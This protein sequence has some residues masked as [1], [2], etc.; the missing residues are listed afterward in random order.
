MEFA[1]AWIKHPYKD[2][3][4]N[5][6]STSMGFGFGVH[7][8]ESA[9]YLE[10]FGLGLTGVREK[11]SLDISVIPL[12]LSHGSKNKNRHVNE[13]STSAHRERSSRHMNRHIVPT[14]RDQRAGKKRKRLE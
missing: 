12:S 1:Y 7:V 2:L 10:S 14:G 4:S 9:M 5:C 13:I 11:K 3:Q 6:D 8:C